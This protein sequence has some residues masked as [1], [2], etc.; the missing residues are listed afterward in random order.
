MK[1]FGYI[2]C[3]CELTLV[4]TLFAEFCLFKCRWS[5]VESS[6]LLLLKSFDDDAD[7]AGVDDAFGVDSVDGVV[8]RIGVLGTLFVVE[9]TAEL[10]F[11]SLFASFCLFLSSFIVYL[12]FSQRSCRKFLIFL[13]LKSSYM[14][15]NKIELL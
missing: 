5:S 1:S 15:N 12:F 14:S 6:R 7:E 2:K 3:V 8:T 10:I 4:Y 13:L 9:D 11:S